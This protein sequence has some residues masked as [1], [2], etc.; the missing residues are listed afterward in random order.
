MIR[1]G[2]G[3][4]HVTKTAGVQERSVRG[5]REGMGDDPSVTSLECDGDGAF[6]VDEDCA[7]GAASE[8]VWDDSGELL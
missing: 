3:G 5:E 4:G 7:G 2:E 6:E 1:S 8:L